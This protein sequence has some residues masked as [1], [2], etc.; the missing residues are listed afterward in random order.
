MDLTRTP[1]PRRISAILAAAAALTLAA[2]CGDGAVDDNAAQEDAGDGGAPVEAAPEQGLAGDPPDGD[3]TDYGVNPEVSTEDDNVSTFALDVDTASYAVTRDNIE[4]G[5]LPDEAAVRTEEIVNYLPQ[6]Y[7]APEEGLGVHL[8]GTDV[9]FL[10]GADRRVL[11]VG[12]QAAETDER[13]PTN[14]TLVID[15]SGSMEGRNMEMVQSAMHTLVDSLESDDEVGIV[16]YSD[17]A[18]LELGMTPISEESAVRDAIDELEPAGA[19]NTEAG[20]R[21]GYDLATDHLREDGNNRVV[22]LSDGVANRGET[23]PEVLAEYVTEA[24]GDEVQLLTVGLGMDVFNDTLLEQLANQGN[25]FYVF[26]DDEREIERVFG[27]DL[28]TTLEAV[29]LDAR[30]QV[31]FDPE[32]VS[33]YRLLGYENRQLDDEEFDDEDTVGG[34]LNSGHTATAVYE[35]TLVDAS[36]E[37]GG[38]E[39]AEVEVAWRDPDGGDMQQDSTSLAASDLQDDFAE[40]PP[41]LRQTIL[42][43]AFA[44]VLRGAP[45]EEHVGLNGVAANARSLADDE[46][47][48]EVV[49]EFA[50]L[51]AT[52][53]DL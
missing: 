50:D 44:E 34:Q 53:S 31:T 7:D 19:T 49:Q 14:L 5:F 47:D 26:V 27:E 38:G 35:V 37:I 23:D 6:D 43:A 33:G 15:V 40:A 30:V 29:A 11:R 3:F 42:A 41:K 22:L 24:G 17:D 20:L 8:D 52:A 2:A 25:G 36:G 12:V 18:D 4:G 39:L 48:D 10:D 9:P 28:T 1:S 21:E 32:T 45:W 16:T 51:T 46:P 13:R